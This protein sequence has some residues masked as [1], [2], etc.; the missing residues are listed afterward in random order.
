M[1]I[2]Q[3]FTGGISVGKN[4]SYFL[5]R[6]KSKIYIMAVMVIMII[7]V[8]ASLFYYSS[9]NSYH[10]ST[11]VN[12]LGRQRML[13]QMIA[14]DTSRLYALVQAKEAGKT[15]EA[16]SVVNKK[17]LNIKQNISSAEKEFSKTLEDINKGTIE[18][19]S[20]KISFDNSTESVIADLK[21]INDLWEN[22]KKSISVIGNSD[23][24]NI[25]F[26]KATIYINDNNELL[27]K[28]CDQVLKSTLEETKEDKLKAIIIVALLVILATAL[29]GITITNMYKYILIPLNEIYKGFSE[30]GVYPSDN[31]LSIITKNEIKPMVNEINQMFHKVEGLISLVENINKNLSFNEVLEYIFKSF[32]QFIPYNHIGVAIA[33]DNG[34]ILEASYGI[35]DGTVR[36]ITENLLNKGYEV[37]GSS[38]EK[39]LKSGEARVIN[40]LQSYA[41]INPPK[42]YTEIILNAGVRSSITLPLNINNR[43][44]G[45][46]FFSSTEK[47]IYREEH[48]RFLSVLANSISICFDKNIFFDDLLYSSILALAKLAEARDEDT[49]EHLERMKKYARLISELLYEESKYSLEISADYIHNIE[50][51]SPMHDIGKVGIKDGILLKPGKLTAEEFQEMKTHA[52]F[53]ASVLKAAE[54]NISKSGRSLFK[55]GIEIAEGHHEKWDGSG[56][57]FGKAGQDI[58]LSARI[59]AVADVFDALTSRRPYKE[60]FSFEASFD[61]IAEGSGKHFDPEIVKVFINNK[62]KI[63]QL[64]RSFNQAYIG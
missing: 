8:L 58:P 14:K 15:V 18:S 45:L 63:Y 28:Y 4:T 30:V 57:P 2:E 64:Y 42:E 1:Y 54:R 55:M 23:G 31:I 60:P 27:L 24:I 12:V 36:G 5:R 51:F 25:E 22:F 39:I 19:G 33:K 56:Y 16:E 48:I 50:R 44:I 41:E 3:Y 20:G 47:N 40:D 10:E 6:V 59:V 37:K 17:I 21:S 34:S 7:A 29:V 32:S 62:A 49:G 53:G 13:T 52:C 61:M 11:L 35:S 43:H 46:I 38:L 26:T 9:K